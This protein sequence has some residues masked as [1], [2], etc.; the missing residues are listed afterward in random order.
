MSGKPKADGERRILV[1]NRKATHD[2]EISE[3][4]EAGIQL[5]GSEVKSLRDSHASIA[6][7]FVEIRGGEAFLVNV[8]IEEYPWA[9][10]FNHEPKRR[11]K[12]LLHKREIGK[13][14][15]LTDQKGMTLLPISIYLKGGTIKVE[16]A[17]GRGKKQYEK[18]ESKRADEAKREIDRAMRR[19]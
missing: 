17:V 6:E 19:R 13:L 9:N 4:Y 7:G 18:R 3:I 5:L 12:L 14:G 1:R 8:Q 11:R 16:V 2:F 10:Q 15:K